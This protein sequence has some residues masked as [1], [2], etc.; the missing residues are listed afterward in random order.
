M[1][2]ARTRTLAEVIDLAITARLAGLHTQLPARVERY[3]PGR[4]LVD[5][6]PLLLGQFEDDD[7]GVLVQALPVITNVPVV[8]PGSGGYRLTFPVQAGDTVWL[9]FGERSI[10]EWKTLGGQV[11]PADPRQHALS[12]AVALVGLRDGQHPWSGAAQDHATLGADGGAQIHIHQNQINLGS[13][14]GV[15]PVALANTLATYLGQLTAWLKVLMMPVDLTKAI[16]GPPQVGP[17][18]PPGL[19]SS[20]VNVQS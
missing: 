8:F 15:E 10:D 12:D 19:G 11:S 20:T 1:T 4:Q 17:P 5:V 16:A 6:V 9:S 7:E 13:D 18:S 2:A 14:A 3:D